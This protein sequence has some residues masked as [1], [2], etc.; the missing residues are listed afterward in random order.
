MADKQKIKFLTALVA[1]LFVAL[2][3]VFSSGRSGSA[4]D[5]SPEPSAE[6]RAAATAAPTPAATSAPQDYV[7]NKNT[8][9]FHYPDCA[10]AA[11]ILGKN[12]EDVFA[13]RDELI[14]RGFKPCG[15]CNP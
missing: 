1:V 12:R 5:P 2:A 14:A 9:R 6:I 3:V 11:E 10:S 15:N 8:K 7:L 13:S 4:S